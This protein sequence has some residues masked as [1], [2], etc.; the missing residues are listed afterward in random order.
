VPAALRLAVL[1][2]MAS[3]LAGCAALPPAAEDAVDIEHVSAVDRAARNQ[4]NQVL[5][6]HYPRRSVEDTSSF[7]VTVVSTAPGLNAEEMEARVTVPME[8][9]L[10]R[11]PK[12]TSVRS[13][14]ENSEVYVEVRLPR[15]TD[16]EA[17]RAVQSALSP[18]RAQLPANA[19]GPVVASTI[20]PRL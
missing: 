15:R 1:A 8:R 12:V 20:E 9:A 2:P 5:W 6:L 10:A 11:V 13:R 3:A 4:G 7:I 17:R 18:V 16:D 19:S 14:T